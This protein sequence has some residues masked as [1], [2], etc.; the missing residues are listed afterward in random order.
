MYKI[1][2]LNMLRIKIRQKKYIESTDWVFLIG[3]TYFELSMKSDSR[4]FMGPRD[5]HTYL[6][7]LFVD[8]NL[9]FQIGSQM[10]DPASKRSKFNFFICRF[11]CHQIGNVIRTV[12]RN[13]FL[14]WK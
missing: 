6:C 3:M 8:N 12:V 11:C 10:L 7:I 13:R 1:T 5:I 9:V 14:F 2:I 4:H